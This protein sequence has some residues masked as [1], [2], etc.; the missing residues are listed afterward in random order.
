MSTGQRRAWIMSEN[1]RQSG[2]PELP[3]Y[4][5]APREQYRGIFH[6]PDVPDDLMAYDEAQCHTLI[7]RYSGVDGMTPGFAK[8]FA[9][10]ISSPLFLAFGERDVSAAPRA[11]AT[12]YPA[13]PD[14]TTVV[15]PDMAHM[16]NFAD[17]RAQLWDRFMTW[18]PVTRT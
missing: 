10:R 2:V 14:I 1:A 9:D 12:G 6:V 17:T 16:H 8:P 15:I 3:M 4:H 7:P 13:S 5:G 18:L 11:E